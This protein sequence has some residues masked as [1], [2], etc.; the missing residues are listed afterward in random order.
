[1]VLKL[2]IFRLD[3]KNRKRCEINSLPS[4]CSFEGVDINEIKAIRVGPFLSEADRD[5]FI[6]SFPKSYKARRSS[7]FGSKPNGKIDFSV[8]YY[9][10]LFE[11]DTFW[12]D[13]VTGEK[14]EAAVKRREKVIAKLKNL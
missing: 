8:R 7:G 14:N 10:V 6:N 12:M 9:S 4:V 5:L 1:M 2:T 3:Y 11:F 13:K